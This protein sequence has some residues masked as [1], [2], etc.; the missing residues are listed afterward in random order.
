MYFELAVVLTVFFGGGAS[1]AGFLP[2][3]PLPPAPLFLSSDQTA[4]QGHCGRHCYPG[5]YASTPCGPGGQ[6]TVCSKCT[7]ATFSVGGLP[8][9]CS[10]CS[11]CTD[12]QY[13]TTDCTQTSDSECADC[14]TCPR[15]QFGSNCKDAGTSHCKKHKVCPTGQYK[16]AAGTAT[17]DTVC[18]RCTPCEAKKF[19]QIKEC[20]AD[21]DAICTRCSI[22]PEGKQIRDE[23]GKTT[24][25]TCGPFVHNGKL[26]GDGWKPF[27]WYNQP[28]NLA[29]KQGKA[30]V[31]PGWISPFQQHY[32]TRK[33]CAWGK[34]DF[35]F[36]RMPK[37]TD[38]FQSELLVMDGPTE[39]ESKNIYKWH[40]LPENPVSHGTFAAM[41]D[42]QETKHGARKNLKKTFPESEKYEWRP[43]VLKGQASTAQISNIQF[44]LAEGFW[45]LQIDDGQ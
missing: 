11:V 28:K 7:G 1:S 35:C 3:A 32:E 17:S 15:G 2:S 19:F 36:S 13:K 38:E 21:A 29:G 8:V 34:D 33:N 6:K 14:S 16:S 45:S 10:A 30:A 4:E 22:C 43:T 12:Q 24:D 26:S 37:D 9:K 31:V 42:H 44:R 23:C 41:R 39:A 20:S 27:M 40:F 5:E 18:N 25:R